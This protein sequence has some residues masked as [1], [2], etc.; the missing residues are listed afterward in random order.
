M[1]DNPLETEAKP[2]RGRLPAAATNNL[3]NLTR[4]VLHKQLFIFVSPLPPNYPELDK[5]QWGGALCLSLPSHFRF[6]ATENFLPGDFIQISLTYHLQG[7]RKQKAPY[8]SHVLGVYNL[9]T[10]QNQHFYF[11]PGKYSFAT[12]VMLF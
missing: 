2:S 5:R 10:K 6:L 1:Y 9:F 11:L 7:E 12:P 3:Y 8:S 4:A